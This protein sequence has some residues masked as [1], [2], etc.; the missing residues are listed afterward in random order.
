MR[1]NSCAM[2][3][4]IEKSGIKQKHVASKAGIDESSLSLILNGKRKCAVDEYLRLCNALQVTFSEFIESETG[5]K[6][7]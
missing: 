5:D 2:R 1:F 3:K 4:Y 7:S 6:A